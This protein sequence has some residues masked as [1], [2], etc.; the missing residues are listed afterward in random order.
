MLGT[1][2][3]GLRQSDGANKQGAEVSH[4]PTTEAWTPVSPVPRGAVNL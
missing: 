4:F 1:L 2:R 3:L